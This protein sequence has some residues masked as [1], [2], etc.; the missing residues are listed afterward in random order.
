M[1][2]TRLPTKKVG[3]P[4]DSF[5]EVPGRL[6]QIRRTRAMGSS[7]LDLG[8]STMLR[9]PFRVRLFGVEEIVCACYDGG[10]D[11]R[12]ENQERAAITNITAAMARSS[13]D[14]NGDF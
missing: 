5:S 12:P 14:E 2:K 7:E 13:G 10:E 9:L 6:A 4:W 8:L 1:V 11:H 3:S